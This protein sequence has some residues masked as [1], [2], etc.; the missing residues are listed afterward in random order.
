MEIKDFFGSDLKNETARTR[1]LVAAILAPDAP[2]SIE[3]ALSALPP[4]PRYIGPEAWLE[5]LA[6]SADPAVGGPEGAPRP[7]GR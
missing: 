5:A 6:L 2:S 3:E 7:R 4:R 1:E